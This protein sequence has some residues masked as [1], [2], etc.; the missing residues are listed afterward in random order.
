[1]EQR[2]PE[3]FPERMWARLGSSGDSRPGRHIWASG[4]GDVSLVSGLAK[5]GSCPNPQPASQAPSEARAFRRWVVRGGKRALSPVFHVKRTGRD[6]W[7]SNNGCNWMLGYRGG[8][9]N[10]CIGSVPSTYLAEPREVRRGLPPLMLTVVR[11]R[12][13]RAG[14]RCPTQDPDVSGV[15]LRAPRTRALKALGVLE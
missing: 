14:V 12:R 3:E 2:F 13:C 8:A 15:K 7:L 11:A 6:G 10:G 5:R 9:L 4:T 1:M